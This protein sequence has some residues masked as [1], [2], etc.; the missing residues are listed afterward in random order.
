MSAGIA[1]ALV[2]HIQEDSTSS[3]HK[4]IRVCHQEGQP[5]FDDKK[6]LKKV[7]AFSELKSLVEKAVEKELDSQCCKP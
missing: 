2:H 3:A 4:M 7:F 6:V 5:D 1:E